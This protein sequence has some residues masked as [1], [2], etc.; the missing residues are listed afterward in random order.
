MNSGNSSLK[1][2]HVD[3]IAAVSRALYMWSKME[4]VRLVTGHITINGKRLT[5]P[6]IDGMLYLKIF[7]TGIL[8]SRS[9]SE[10][11]IQ[12]S[13]TCFRCLQ[14]PCTG[15]YDNNYPGW[16]LVW[17]WAMAPVVCV[18]EGH[19]LSCW[20]PGGHCLSVINPAKMW[21]LRNM[22]CEIIHCFHQGHQ[23]NIIIS[24]AVLADEVFAFTILIVTYWRYVL[25]GVKFLLF[26]RSRGGKF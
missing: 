8:N 23:D 4:L 26:S 11:N 24:Q 17:P 15:E 22:N 20:A 25:A 12:N 5:W 21:A 1:P 2:N 19:L 18:R 10:N 3:A 6:M 7:Y 16:H 9:L 13:M 14:K